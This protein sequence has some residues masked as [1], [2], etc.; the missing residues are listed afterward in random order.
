MKRLK[1]VCKRQSYQAIDGLKTSLHGFVDGLS[2]DNTRGLN[3]DSLSSFSSDG[4]VTINGV[5]MKL[6]KGDGRLDIPKSVEHSSQH[7]FTDGDIDDGT[8]SLD[9]VTFLNFSKR[10][11][12][13][14][15]RQTHLSLPKTT[16]PTLSV[17]KLR[18]IP[19]TPEENSTISPAWTLERPKT[20]AIPSP[21]EIT[22][23]NSWMLF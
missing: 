3:F 4:T 14:Q 2:G 16:I 11:Q 1:K 17:S 23:P 10:S 20:L 6:A 12:S 22:V 18:A 15:G 19:L 5:T 21:M 9:D 13:R 7:F 8:S